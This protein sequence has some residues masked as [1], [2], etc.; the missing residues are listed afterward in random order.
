MLCYV[1]FISIV[2]FKAPGRGKMED[3]VCKCLAEFNIYKPANQTLGR[4]SKALK[5]CNGKWGNC[6]QN[7]RLYGHVYNSW[8]N[9]NVV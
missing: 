4:A 8:T 2:N 9:L 3:F 1:Q 7:G 5:K 6:P